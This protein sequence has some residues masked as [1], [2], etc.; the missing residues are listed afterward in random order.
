MKGQDPGNAAGAQRD[1]Y[2]QRRTLPRADALSW[3]SAQNMRSENNRK[4]SQYW[5]PSAMKTILW[6]VATTGLLIGSAAIGYAQQGSTSGGVAQ[7]GSSFGGAARQ[8]SAFGGAAQQGSTFGGT[9][10]Q[11]STLGG[12]AQQGSTF[13]GTAQ[14]G[15]TFGGAAQQGST[16]D[17]AAQQGSTF[18]GAGAAQQGGTTSGA[19]A[20]G[21]GVRGNPGQ[22]DLT[23]G[24]GDRSGCTTQT[25]VVPSEQTGDKTSVGVTRC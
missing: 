10:Q 8:G 5:D 12:A 7:Q 6:L 4:T 24:R 22:D 23:I 11:G 21:R 13:G 2:A 19:A 25:Y 9:A 20:P 17:G 14:Q 15:S 1:L 16:F 18:G 3:Q